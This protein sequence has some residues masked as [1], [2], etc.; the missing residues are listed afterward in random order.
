MTP[1]ALPGDRLE[2]HLGKDCNQGELIFQGTANRDC[3]GPRHGRP[4]PLWE[5]HRLQ[6][7]LIP[8]GPT[9][10]PIYSLESSLCCGA[11][12]VCE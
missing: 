12:D 11:S 1:L 4:S 8:N 2:P 6:G 10:L 5:K 7:G 9:P 3:L